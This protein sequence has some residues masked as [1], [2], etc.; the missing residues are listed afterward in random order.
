MAT[1]ALVLAGPLWACAPAGHDLGWIHGCGS[2][3]GDAGREHYYL[4]FRRNQDRYLAD[5]EYRK[6][7][8]GGYRECFEEEQRTPYVGGATG[9]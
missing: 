7:W 9:M 1:A 3:Y 5:A 8:D 4:E 6:G 2:G